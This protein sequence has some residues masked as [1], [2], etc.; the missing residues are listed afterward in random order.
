MLERTPRRA[1]V[2]LAL[3]HPLA[4]EVPRGA[5]VRVRRARRRPTSPPS[6][7]SKLKGGNSNWRGPLWFPTYVPHHRD[8]AQARH[9]VRADATSST[10]PGRGGQPIALPGDRARYLPP[11]DRHLL[12]RREPAAAGVRRRAR[13][14]PTIRTGATSCSSTSTSTATTAPASA[15]ATRRGGP[16]W[17]RT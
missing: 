13:S 6:R 7:P 10:T 9:R 5:A 8:P 2:P 16:R 15:R 1:R 3:R 11:D 12:A 4:V 17:S 14:S